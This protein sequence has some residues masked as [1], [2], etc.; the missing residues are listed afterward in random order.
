[1]HDLVSQHRHLDI[2][3][4]TDLCF[5][6]NAAVEILESFFFLWSPSPEHVALKFLITYQKGAGFESP[7]PGILILGFFG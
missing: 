6:L 7:N 2:D 5:Q 4:S 3:E 1:M